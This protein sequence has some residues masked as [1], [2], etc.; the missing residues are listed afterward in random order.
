M[1]KL[2]IT[3]DCFLP[4]WDGIARFLDQLLPELT[5]YFEVTVAAPRFAGKPKDYQCKIVRFPVGTTYFGDL[6]FAHPTLEEVKKLVEES[7]LVF[8]QTIGPIGSK[9]IK[10]AHKL[11]KP[12]ISFVHNIEWEL[13]SR[14][15]RFGK[16]IAEQLIK[17]YARRLYNKCTKLI[18]P[19]RK[20]EDLLSDNKIKTSKTIIPLG[21][22]GEHFSP[23]LSKPRAKKK[24]GIPPYKTIIG[25][26][27]RLAREKDV[28]TL[29]KAFKKL[30]RTH[31]DILLLLVGGGRTETQYKHP[32]IVVT[33]Q[34][35]NVVPYYQAMDIYV[36]PS[37]TETS[38]LTTMEAMATGLPVI[39]TPVGTLPEYVVDGKNGF[40]FPRK[41]I[42][43]LIEKLEKLLHDESLRHYIG[44]NARTT[45]LNKHRWDESKKK[46]LGLLQEY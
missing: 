14:A 26:V 41:D 2:L 7:D 44:A 45:V 27:G 21:I 36:L 43:E 18:V 31:K 1:K 19:S 16:W 37:L 33:G 5:K 40:F 17:I 3:T 35:S 9:A 20:I 11:K 38:S 4:R 10:T 29:A 6:Q 34:V 8:N 42:E 25:F 28:G 39:V 12:V 24:I 22:Q 46:I 15:V 30:L 32:K 23:P 13:A